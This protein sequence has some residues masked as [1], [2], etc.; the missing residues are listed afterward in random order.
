MSLL[1]F[2]TT[3][4]FQHAAVAQVA[5]FLAVFTTLWLAEVLIV[6]KP[7]KKKLQHT[8][9]NTLVM[10]TVLP[11]QLGMSAVLLS[12]AAW[13]TQHHFGLVWLLPSPESGW[14]KYVLMF[15]VLDLLDYV[16]H[17]SVHSIGLFW[18]FHRVHHS[19]LEMDVTTTFREH[20]G[21]TV[22][23]MCFLI[24]F[25]FLCGASIGVLVIRQIAQSICNILQHTTFRLQG[26]MGKI[27]GWL[28]LTPNLHHVHHHYQLPYT[29]CNYG[30][31]FSIWDRLFGTLRELPATETVFGVDTPMD[32]SA[33]STFR[34]IMKMPFTKPQ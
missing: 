21:D 27:C 8:S 12:T 3:F 14:V 9:C 15:F 28:F 25:V 30:D 32:E 19:D 7:W 11:V 22:V 26:R 20:P 6:A 2:L 24:M 29:N 13:T 16:Y 10:L 33:N 5:L 1:H 17:V 34:G 31:V 23:R 18:R 4:F